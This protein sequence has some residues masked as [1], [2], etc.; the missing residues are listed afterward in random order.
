MTEN[1]KTLGKLW[2]VFTITDE[3]TSP[4]NSVFHAKICRR[5]FE[6]SPRKSNNCCLILKKIEYFSHKAVV[7][8]ELV[9][10]WYFMQNL[11][12]FGFIKFGKSGVKFGKNV[13]FSWKRPIFGKKRILEK[14]CCIT[15]WFYGNQVQ[16]SW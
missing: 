10:S 8:E 1:N 6:N 16:V 15:N 5:F 9:Y 14:F 11:E 7:W 4:E 12:K 3:G 2:D 13:F